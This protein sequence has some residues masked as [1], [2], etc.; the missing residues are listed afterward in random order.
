MDDIIRA[1]GSVEEA[2]VGNVKLAN[3]VHSKQ[4]F[5]NRDK[6][7]FIMF[8]NKANICEAREEVERS[9]IW[10]GNFITKEKKADK[11]LGDIFHQDGLAES[12][13]AT[14]KDR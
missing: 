4:L 8:G 12:V 7:W 9:P 10:C 1:L 6:T 3:I 11:W 5:L 2:R 14:I 13:V